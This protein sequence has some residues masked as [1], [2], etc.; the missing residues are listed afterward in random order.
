[1][2]TLG[3]KSFYM[4]EYHMIKSVVTAQCA[5]CAKY[6][7]DPPTDKTI[8]AW[9]K[10]FTETG[11]LCKQK[12]SGRPL[13]TEDDN[14]RVRASFLHSPK[15]SKGKQQSETTVWRV[16]CKRLVFKPYRIQMVQQLL[17]E[18]DS[19]QLDFCLV[20]RLNEFQ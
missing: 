10:K 18:D 8:R 20:T 2:A 5:F 4:L 13:T 3:E 11:C 12:S 17:D 15:K 7:K 9:Y 16:L 14:D 6:V 1:M 19:C